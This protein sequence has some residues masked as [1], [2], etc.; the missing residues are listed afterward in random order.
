MYTDAIVH[1]VFDTC[2]NSVGSTAKIRINGVEWKRNG[3]N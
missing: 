1:L 2:M 3:S